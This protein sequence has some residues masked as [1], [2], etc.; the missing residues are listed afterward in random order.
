MSNLYKDLS[1]VY[2]AMYK[3]LINYEEEYTFY[4][5]L[6][7]KYKCQSVLEIACGTGNLTKAFEANG[8]EY[9]GLD[10]AEKMLEMAR[11]KNPK[12][13]FIQGNMKEFTLPKKVQSALITAR[14]ISYLVENEEVDAAFKAIKSNL[15]KGGLLCFD[16]IDANRFIPYIIKNPKVRHEGTDKGIRYYRD[17]HWTVNYSRSWTFDW[18]A[19]YYKQTREQAIH[20]ASDHATVRA[21][22]VQD[23]QLLLSMNGFEVLE[24]IDRPSYT[25]DTFVFVAKLAT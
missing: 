20:I 6:L 1:A 2:E 4:S 12:S 3:S 10:L 22:T 7:K 21:F 19:R 25:F 18:L 16:I 8:F 13:T 14:S 24:V 5:Q 15:L 23:I 9:I 17:T 11:L